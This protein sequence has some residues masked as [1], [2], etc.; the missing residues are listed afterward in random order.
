MTLNQINVNFHGSHGKDTGSNFE[1]TEFS[2]FTIRLQQ[3][4]IARFQ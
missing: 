3:N 2:K 1:K 4:I